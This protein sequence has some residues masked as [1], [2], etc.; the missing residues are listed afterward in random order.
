MKVIFSILLSIV[1]LCGCAKKSEI[2]N[3]PNPNGVYINPTA[4]YI[5]LGDS[6]TIGQSIPLDM[7]FPFQLTKLLGKEQI[8]D[9]TIIAATGWTTANLIYAIEENSIKNRK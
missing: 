6:Y 4:R 3:K 5:A 1:V 9:P 8:G 7:A 2:G